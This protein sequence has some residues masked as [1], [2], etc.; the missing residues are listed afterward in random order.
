MP[1]WP[2]VPLY[3]FLVVVAFCRA[4][5]TYL[6][7]RGARGA[8]GRRWS[9]DNAWLA[10]GEE[11]VRR[12]GAPAVTLCFLTVGVQTAVNLAAGTLRM[13]LRRY[14]PAL[15]L[16]ALIWAGVY[17]TV[18]IAVVETFWGGSRPWALLGVLAAVAA[19]AVLVRHLL[20][21]RPQH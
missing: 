1:D 3:A 11:V 14:V 18:G 10:R 19:T 4:G 20:R 5:G 15:F 16:G 7:G 2:V 6:V 8:A 17:L 9:L 21:R 13:P 12:F